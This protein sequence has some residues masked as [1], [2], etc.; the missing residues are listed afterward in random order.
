M[1]ITHNAI[2]LERPS[3]LSRSLV[4]QEKKQRLNLSEF[5][6]KQ[7]K[8]IK[9][10]LQLDEPVEMKK[11]KK[12]KGVNPLST[13]KKTKKR[14]EQEQQQTK[15][16]KKR[17]RTRQLRISAHWKDFLRDLEKNFSIREFLG[18]K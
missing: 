13:K 9:E 6:T 3:D 16:K 12:R 17:R 8:L 15:P 10:E 7:L 18:M 1:L 11:K 5:E 4:E 2:N 14:L